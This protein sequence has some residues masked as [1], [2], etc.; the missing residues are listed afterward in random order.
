MK[1]DFKLLYQ[2]LIYQNIASHLLTINQLSIYDIIYIYIRLLVYYIHI[3]K[4]NLHIFYLLHFSLTGE[5][6][7]VD[8]RIEIDD[9]YYVLLS[10][11]GDFKFIIFTRKTLASTTGE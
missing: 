2:V 10:L 1:H 3:T 4:Y 11:T 9:T 6:D 8:R 7:L 5:L